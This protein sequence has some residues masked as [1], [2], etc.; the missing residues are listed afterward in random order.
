MKILLLML[1]VNLLHS[2]EIIN[3]VK[4]NDETNKS[5][6][7]APSIVYQNGIL[8]S[9]WIDFRNGNN[10]QIWFSKSEDFG[11]T[12]SKNI[13]VYNSRIAN[14]F[15]QRASSISVF[16]ENVYLSW[17][18][19]NGNST[20]IFF[21]KSENSGDSF[22][23]PRLVSN[24][25]LKYSQDF[26]A[27]EVDEDGNIHII[28]IDNR[29]L[30]QKYVDH[31]ELMYTKSTDN[32]TTWS[33]LKILCTLENGNGGACE[34][35]WP[36]ISSK[37]IN[38][39]INISVLYRSNIDNLRVFYLAKSIDGGAN[40]EYP[41]RIG[42]ENWMINSCPVSGASIDYGEGAD[43]HI[44][45]RIKDKL[46]YSLYNENYT[47]NELNIGSGEKPN[48]SFN[49]IT[50]EITFSYEIFNENKNVIEIKK[51]VGN[52]IENV[53]SLT[54]GKDFSGYLEY[55]N[56]ENRRFVIWQDNSSGNDDIW[57][58]ELDLTTQSV[59]NPFTID[60]GNIFLDIEFINSS[61][62][63]YNLQG[64]KVHFN[65]QLGLID[66]QS[67]NSGYYILKI[68]TN[69]KDYFYKFVK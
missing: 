11:K 24:D 37:K 64:N 63:I 60:K 51:L 28:F 30:Q 1:I 47:P 61:I 46:Y 44:V 67:I 3:K 39:E 52:N 14:S 25:S 55:V 40:F 19:S 21:A 59:E 41:E 7:R 62:E 50:K 6:Q 57:F 22:L 49:D 45:Y 36:V 48:I 58:G 29:N 34:C 18:A 35:C 5:A 2:A 32:G 10:G 16:G 43:L 13:M 8:Y 38:G 69:S 20:D 54:N 31:A 9:S 53:L 23:M 33:D 15:Y 26:S 12:W 42:I 66:I 17:M 27:M 56:I 4:I 65:K 68:S